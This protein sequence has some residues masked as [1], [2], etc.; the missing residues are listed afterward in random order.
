MDAGLLVLREGAVVGG[1]GGHAEDRESPLVLAQI[2][3]LLNQKGLAL[4]HI[5]G[6]DKVRYRCSEDGTQLVLD[7]DDATQESYVCAVCGRVMD[8]VETPEVRMVTVVLEEES[9]EDDD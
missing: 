2:D 9:E 1:D 5:H 6:D 7:K 8:K 4:P 3:V